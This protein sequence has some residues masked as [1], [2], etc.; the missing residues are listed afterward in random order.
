VAARS[1]RQVVGQFPITALP[2]AV[3]MHPLCWSLLGLYFRYGAPHP[4]ISSLSRI[5]PI[6]A[7]ARVKIAVSPQHFKQYQEI[8]AIVGDT[9]NRTITFCI[10]V[11]QTSPKGNGEIEATPS[12]FWVQRNDHGRWRTLL[13]GPDVG[14]FRADQVPEVGKSLDFPFRLSNPGKVRLR[15][16]YWRGPIPNMD[17]KASRKHSKLA[18]SAV[19][20]VE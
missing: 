4:Y 18:T 20:T 16:M 5:A 13:I 1:E 15:L 19:F 3:P 17:C 10:E 14:S 9:G 2:D 6:A 12:P 11:G 7:M 8:R